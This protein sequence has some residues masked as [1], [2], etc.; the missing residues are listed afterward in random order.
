VLGE[1]GIA[2]QYALAKDRKGHLEVITQY[3]YVCVQNCPNHVA[4][5][6]RVE[7]FFE[8][9]GHFHSGHYT[10]VTQNIL[11]NK[12]AAFFPLYHS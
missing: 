10:T 12:P 7:S 1:L 6:Y 5:A 3:Q 4:P 9:V 2:Q 8:L 11:T